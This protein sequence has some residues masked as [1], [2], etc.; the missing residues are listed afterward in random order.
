M[1]TTAFFLSAS[2]IIGIFA[3]L[4]FY[5]IP[6]FAVIYKDAV[7]TGWQAALQAWPAHLSIGIITVMISGAVGLFIGESEKERK[8]ALALEAAKEAENEAAMTKAVAEQ[9]IKDAQ[10]VAMDQEKKLAKCQQKKAELDFRLKNCRETNERRKEDN[11]SGKA[12]KKALEDSRE[13]KQRI[14]NLEAELEQQKGV[15]REL[16]RQVRELRTTTT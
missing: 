3:W 10:N 13:N 14:L 6:D 12:S 8:A 1:K 15:N 4:H 5:V 16:R 11:R 2:V 7:Y 9:A